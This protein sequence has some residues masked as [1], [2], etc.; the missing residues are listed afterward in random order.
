MPD[1]LDVVESRLAQFRRDVSDQ[2][3]LCRE[4]GRRRPSTLTILALEA[5]SPPVDRLSRLTISPTPPGGR[6]MSMP[7]LTLHTCPVM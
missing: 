1:L 6:H 5:N 3:P 4:S 2:S 7:P